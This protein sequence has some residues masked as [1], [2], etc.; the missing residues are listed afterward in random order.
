MRLN[1]RSFAMAGGIFWGVG[2][3]LITWW[4]IALHGCTV[5]AGLLGRLYPGY[6]VSAR[7]SLMGL[8]W[9]LADGAVSA[10][11]FAAIYNLALTWRVGQDRGRNERAN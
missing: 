4:L 6:A 2:L 7:G 11:I 8:V 5:D 3:F 1:V 9:G 10:A